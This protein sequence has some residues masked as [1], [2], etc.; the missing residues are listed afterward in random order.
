MNNEM[1]GPSGIVL[2]VAGTAIPGSS[3][4]AETQAESAAKGNCAIRTRRD[5]SWAYRSGL[6]FLHR[7]FLVALMLNAFPAHAQAGYV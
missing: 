7:L 5:T 3:F 1:R 4:A 2:A 6:S